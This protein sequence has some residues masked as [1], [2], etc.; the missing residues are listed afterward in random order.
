M[1]GQSAA[2]GIAT[3]AVLCVFAL[4]PLLQRPELHEHVTVLP[5]SAE[6]FALPRPAPLIA[7]FGVLHHLVDDSARA[8]ALHTTCE[9]LAPGGAFLAEI[10]LSPLDAQPMTLSGERTI[11][12]I[13]YRKFSG[14]TRL[15][16]E[17]YEARYVY[18]LSLGDQLVE[19]VEAR[20]LTRAWTSAQLREHLRD[21][22]FA[23]WDEYGDDTRT[24]FAP[25][26]Q[27][28]LL[29]ARRGEAGEAQSDD[30]RIGMGTDH[31]ARIHGR[32]ESG[33]RDDAP[34]DG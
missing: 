27:R 31:Q 19:R 16:D 8:A 13:T 17:V 21:A 29:L 18:E 5:G 6:Q 7:C 24:P 15:S 34:L 4:T 2:G 22:G 20:S 3:S 33:A 28:L 14:R 30:S 9:Q 10:N 1:A 12:A 25:E 23:R 26:M 11:G 32:S